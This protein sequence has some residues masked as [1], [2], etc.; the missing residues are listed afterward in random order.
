M[1]V[2]INLAPLK[3][4]GGQ[5]VGLNLLSGLETLSD[6]EVSLYFYVSAGSAIGAAVK[7]KYADRVIEGPHNTTKRVMFER[8]G[9]G[10]Y[11]RENKIDI[12]YSCFGYACVSRKYRQV[13]GMA[14][15][16]IMYPEIDFWKEYRGIRK[17]GK[18]VID[19]YRKWGYKRADALVFENE[20]MY[21]RAS[22]IF[23]KDKKA[24]YIKPSINVSDTEGQFEFEKRH[25]DS[26]VGLFLCGWQL[27]KNIMCI[28]ELIDEMRKAG[29]HFEIIIT[30]DEND[31]NEIAQA[32]K[33]KL[34]SMAVEECVHMVGR[35][36]KNDLSALYDK[37]DFVFLLSRLESFS[38]NIIEA[39]HY[40]KPLV[41][42]DQE[43][44]HGICRDAA[45]YVDRDDP[46]RIVE[47]LLECIDGGRAGDYVAKGVAEYRSYPSIEERTRQEMRYVKEIAETTE[48]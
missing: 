31:N 26:Y 44:A 6:P 14:E 1:N 27:N 25:E 20:A 29:R 9:L 28:P 21:K 42:S 39:W 36:D 18:N 41:I 12:I 43:W 47:K 45:L 32:F 35:V 22:Q 33:N 19:A 24:T 8:T 38:N 17:L 23:G 7:E 11:L 40:R 10:K 16:N 46:V 48:V 4:G 2:L 37:V 30:V 5:N 34:R 3:A 13:C 15:S